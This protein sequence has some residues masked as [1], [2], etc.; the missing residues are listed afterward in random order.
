MKEGFSQEYDDL[1]KK[2][3]DVEASVDTGMKKIK[4]PRILITGIMTTEKGIPLWGWYKQQIKD[5]RTVSANGKPQYV[6]EKDKGIVMY[7]GRNN[8]SRFWEWWDPN[9]H[10]W[11]ISTRS[12]AR[13]WLNE[14]RPGTFPKKNGWFTNRKWHTGPPR[15]GNWRAKRVDGAYNRGGGLRVKSHKWVDAY[16]PG[17]DMDVFPQT[18]YYP[19]PR[20]VTEYYIV[21]D[22]KKSHQ[23]HD[24]LAKSIGWELVPINS[25]EDLQ[26]LRDVTSL[27][28]WVASTSK[29]IPGVTI[30][31]GE[32]IKTEGE[33]N[34]YIGDLKCPHIDDKNINLVRYNVDV[35]KC[36]TARPAVYRRLITPDYQSIA[37]HETLLTQLYKDIDTLK[38]IQKERYDTEYSYDEPTFKELE[39]Q[40]G[41]IDEGF[42]NQEGFRGDTIED[43]YE[44]GKARVIELKRKL[45]RNKTIM[46]PRTRV[47]NTYFYKYNEVQKNTADV[48][49][50]AK[51][52]LTENK[53]NIKNDIHQVE[54]QTS[55]IT[56][57]FDPYKEYFAMAK[58]ENTYM[59]KDYDKLHYINRYVL[60]W[61]YFALLLILF[62]V[63]TTRGGHVADYTFYLFFSFLVL[64]P[65]IIYP[66]QLAM[67]YIFKKIYATVSTNKLS[68]ALS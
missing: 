25:K 1:M 45:L 2:I 34:L 44:A 16:I 12:H 55:Q 61:V 64:F 23:Q 56:E 28:V 50:E 66:F 36:M 68:K 52:W 38:E 26:K 65:F 54:G 41:E 8:S 31:D 62:A 14:Q 18:K 49:K 17:E 6:N 46:A 3:K 22:S 27:P 20:P 59:F 33:F 32:N 67:M 9:A 29:Y 60:I 13:A 11:I 63:V 37:D 7:W 35:D 5:G 19:A 57:K 30:I 15:H 21:N 53:E 24:E 43:A 51:F 47:Y 4:I 39:D 42:E 58:R 10:G 40:Y 48:K